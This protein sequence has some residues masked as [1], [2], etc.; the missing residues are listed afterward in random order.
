M[1]FPSSIGPINGASAS[2]FGGVNVMG[3]MQQGLQNAYMQ[4]MLAQKLAQQQ[5]ATQQ[6]GIGTQ[7]ARNILTYQNPL[8]MQNLLQQQAQTGIQQAQNRY[9]DA[10]QY[11][12]AQQQ[13]GAGKVEQGMGEYTAAQQSALSENMRQQALQQGITSQFLPQQYR[14]EQMSMGLS[15][16]NPLMHNLIAMGYSGPLRNLTGSEAA[17]LIAR[18][19]VHMPNYNVEFNPTGSAASSKSNSVSPGTEYAFKDGIKRVYT[20]SNGWIPLS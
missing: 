11:G 9:A 5:Q 1:Y 18:T 16:L 2:P 15:G 17:D 20:T 14:T 3:A 10:Q 12:I 13:L 7:A 8:L 6:A 4:P 19:G